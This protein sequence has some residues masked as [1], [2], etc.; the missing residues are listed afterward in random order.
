M[1]HVLDIKLIKTNITLD[2]NQKT[3][4]GMIYLVSSASSYL[5]AFLSSFHI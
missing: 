4:K 1:A 2:L 5:L 3:E